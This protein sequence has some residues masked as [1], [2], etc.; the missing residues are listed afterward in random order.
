[1]FYANDDD[2]CVFCAAEY[3]KE[4]NV[5]ISAADKALRTKLSGK[6][7][8][9]IPIPAIRCTICFDHIKKMAE[10]AKLLDES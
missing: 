1:M 4:N 10:G 7:V 6:R 3:A 9:R 5:K 8:Y 2:V